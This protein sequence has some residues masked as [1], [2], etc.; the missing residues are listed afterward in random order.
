MATK[1]WIPIL[2][3]SKIVG[4]ED[5]KLALEVAYIA[6]A[7]IGGVL[8]RGDR[9][10]GKSTIVRAFAQMMFNGE[11]PI[12]LPINATEDRVVGGLKIDKLLKQEEQWQPGLLE[13]ADGNILYVDEVNLLDDHIINLI[14]DTAAT[15]ILPIQRQGKDEK[16]KPTKFTLVGTMNPEEG[17]LRAQLRD[18][19]GLMVDVTTNTEKRAEILQTMLAFD[20]ALYENGDQ[21]ILEEGKA[22]NKNKQEALQMA[23]KRLPQVQID[24]PMINLC[25][26]LSA[27]IDTVGH[28]GAHVLALAAKALAARDGELAVTTDHIHRLAPM[29]LAHRRAGSPHWTDKDDETVVRVIDLTHA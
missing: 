7:R 21:T 2:P 12:T 23:Q 27:E 24:K 18:R 3:Y 25:V 22:E 15:G 29:A 13:Q 28:R 8:L 17:Y 19:F 1:E 26:Q 9:G 20:D 5:V 16:G 6:G 11:L 10:T 14:L 4:Q